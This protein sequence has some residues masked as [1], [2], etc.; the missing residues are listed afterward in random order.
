MSAWFLDSELST[1]YFELC[2]YTVR[3]STHSSSIGVLTSLLTTS[4][5]YSRAESGA[6]DI[7]ST[8]W[9]WPCNSALHSFVDATH[10]LT[11]YKTVWS[12]DVTWLHHGSPDHLNSLLAELHQDWPSLISP[13]LYV[14]CMFSHKTCN[15]GVAA[16]KGWGYMMCRTYP[17][18]TSHILIVASRDEETRKSPEGMK[19]TNDT[20]WSW[21]MDM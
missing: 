16:S 9:E 1:C 5:T 19:H 10:T 18:A 13:S 4:L 6:H 7:H 21:P 15:V 8:T 3:E 17:L 14:H 20:L 11:V 12:H 2:I